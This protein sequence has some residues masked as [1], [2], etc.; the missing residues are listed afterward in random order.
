MILL[1]SIILKCPISK[2]K[3]K[4]QIEEATD[5]MF[6]SKEKILQLIEGHQFHE[7][8]ALMMKDCFAY[9]ETHL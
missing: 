5:Y 8:H 1:I 7:K 3:I 6:A 4:L 9:L 2:K